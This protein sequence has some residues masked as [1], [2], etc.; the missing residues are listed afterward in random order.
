M[1]HYQI[2]PAWIDP[3]TGHAC[4]WLRRHAGTGAFAILLDIAIIRALPDG[5]AAI[6]PAYD[7][8]P[9][10]S[11][12]PEFTRLFQS[13]PAAIETALRDGADL[14]QRGST[15]CINAV[16]RPMAA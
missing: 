14:W 1:T 8:A 15:P 2:S 13:L 7:L 3:E 9:Y 5:R 10:G 4:R 16:A 11:A 12:T 6:E